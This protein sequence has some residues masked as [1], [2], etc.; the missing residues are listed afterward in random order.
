MS[1]LGEEHEYPFFLDYGKEGSMEEL[2]QKR[3]I[4]R[5][6]E[7]RLERK[8]LQEA[9]QDDFDELANQFDNE[10]WKDASLGFA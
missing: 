8:R 5:T 4:R 10:D 1:L 9:C 6:L 3:L 7:E 2:S